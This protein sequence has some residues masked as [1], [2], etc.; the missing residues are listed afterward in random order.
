M[1]LLKSFCSLSVF[2]VGAVALVMPR[3]YSLGFFLACVVGLL[4]W[5]PKREPL[6]DANTKWLIWPCVAYALG[7]MVIGL[8]H[9]WAWRSLDA[10][11]PFVL[12]TFG[13]WAVRRYK[14]NA[15]FFWSGLALGAVGAACLAGYQAQVLGARADGF[16]QAIQFGNAAL[17]MGVLC[18]VRLLTV[19][20]NKW[21]D[22]LML[23]GFGAGLAASVWSQSRGG[24]L[25]V[26]LILAWMLINATQGWQP[27]KRMT[28]AMA[29][30]F[31]LAIPA[32]QPNGIV[33]NRVMTAVHEVESYW[34]SNVQASSVGS[35]LAMWSF[36]AKDIANAPL[37]GQ[38]TEGW[39]HNRDAGIQ[40]G[41][42]DPFVK[43]FSHLHN[44]FLDVTYKTGLIGLAL[45]LALYWLPMLMFFKPYLH[46]YGAEVKALAMGGMV[47]PMMYMDF[48]LTQAFLS[49]NSGRMVFVSLLMCLGALL[50]NATEPSTP[51]SPS[52][53]SH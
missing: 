9:Q 44:E 4:A 51:S 19:R 33:Q 36:A 15:L 43:D 50:M 25:A 10:Y 8:T 5:L 47:L 30:L 52:A 12:V 16:N 49:H 53:P 41:A 18:L 34:L 39:K 35:R 22:A 23:L 2:L 38:G 40:S 21:M 6:V 31:V 11:V 27:A 45:L 42:L 7:H 32:L 37:I 48:G 24:W 20:G 17:L 13:V 3:G 28:A 1:H 26:L 29:L 46:G 14:P